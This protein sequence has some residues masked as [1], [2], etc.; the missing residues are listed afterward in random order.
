MFSSQNSMSL[1]H[2]SRGICLYFLSVVVCCP[3]YFIIHYKRRR[4]KKEKE[5]EGEG[6]GSPFQYSCLENPMDRGAWRSTVHVV[7]KNQTW[8]SNWTATTTNSWSF[9]LCLLTQPGAT[10]GWGGQQAVVSAGSSFRNSRHPGIKKS[11]QQPLS[12][13]LGQESTQAVQAVLGVGLRLCGNWGLL[14][15]GCWPSQGLPGQGYLSSISTGPEE[16]KLWGTGDFTLIW[17]IVVV[18]VQ[19]PSHVRLSVTPWTWACQASL[20]LIW[21]TS[22]SKLECY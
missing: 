12:R 21:V 7:T 10:G 6:N 17:V 8:L 13:P 4:K 11:S 3:L 16:I 19:S 20:S 18:V 15:P 5:K 1:R 2:T 14:K 22:G 9:S